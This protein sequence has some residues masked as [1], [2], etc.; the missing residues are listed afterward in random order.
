MM[1]RA[2]YENEQRLTAFQGHESNNCPHPRT[3]ESKPLI[4]SEKEAG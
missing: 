3:T 4:K 1:M 2:S